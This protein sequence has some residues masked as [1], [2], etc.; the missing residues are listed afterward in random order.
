MRSAANNH[1]VKKNNRLNTIKTILAHKRISQPALAKILGHSGP[2]VLQNIKELNALGLIQEAGDLESTGGRKAKAW[3]PIAEAQYAI[4]LDITKNHLIL[5]L[6][7]L[8]TNI[9]YS[10]VQRKK[11]EPTDD[12]YR[13]LA[14]LTNDSLQEMQIPREKLA[15]IGI[16][17]PGTV[18]PELRLLVSSHVFSLKN[19]STDNFSRYLPAP[20]FFINDANAAGFAEA[21][22]LNHPEN[23]VYLSLS[24]SVGGAIINSEKLYM[25]DYLKAGEFGHMTLVPDGL[26]CYCGKRGCVDAYCNAEVLSSHTNGNLELF[27]QQQEHDKE[28]QEIWEQYQKNLAVVVNNLHMIF[29]C[30]VMVGGYIGSYLPRYAPNFRAMLAERNTFEPDCAYMQYCTYS[31]QE[32][33]ATGAALLPLEQYLLDMCK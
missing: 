7:N 9:V 19:Y 16:S 2:T 6:I 27:F 14:D 28:L 3:K 25:G 20:C 10:S 29:D 23:F 15:G 30:D 32:A 11:F 22:R 17:L 1:D 8:V 31:K 24:N 33:A 13:S 26:P 4:G 21:H 12:Y 5:V 18:D